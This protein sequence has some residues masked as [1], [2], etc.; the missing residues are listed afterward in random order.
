[1]Q[2]EF[3]FREKE[4]DSSW[5]GGIFSKIMGLPKLIARVIIATLA[6][7]VILIGTMVCGV[8]TALDP[9][10]IFKAILSLIS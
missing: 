6:A 7:A 5:F 4:E 3:I 10:E 9:F 8:Q 2:K 1:M